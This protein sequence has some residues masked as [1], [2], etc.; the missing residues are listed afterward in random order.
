MFLITFGLNVYGI[1][2][3]IPQIEIYIRRIKD[4]GKDWEW[5]FINL[6][7]VLGS[8]L[9]FFWLGFGKKGNDKKKFI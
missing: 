9:C 2:C 8:I 5:I 6:T 1:V 3:I 7:P 4:F